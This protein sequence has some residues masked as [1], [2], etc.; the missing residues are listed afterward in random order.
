MRGVR[1]GDIRRGAGS[2][3]VQVC[4]RKREIEIEIE[5]G[6]EREWGHPKP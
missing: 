1:G 4:E 2:R 5:T 3:V 6:R